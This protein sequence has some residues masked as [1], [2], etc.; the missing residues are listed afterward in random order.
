[1]YCGDCGVYLATQENDNDKI[2]QYVVILN[3]TF[4]ETLC[5]G[6]GAKRRSLHC[7]KIC[8]FIQ[9][10]KEKDVDFYSDCKEFP[11]FALN[12]FKSKMPHSVK[13]LES[14]KMMKEIGIENWIIEMKSYFACPKCKVENSAY[15]IACRKCGNTPGSKFVSQHKKMVEDYLSK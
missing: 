14:Q 3:Q 8:N 15:H 12:E 9:C 6:C 5:D 4:E 7:S 1:M 11:C 10:K 2:L 13:I